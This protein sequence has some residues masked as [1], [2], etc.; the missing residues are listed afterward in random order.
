MLDFAAFQSPVG[1]LELAAFGDSLVMCDWIG[2]PAHQAS[3]EKIENLYSGQ[4]LPGGKKLLEEASVQLDEYFSGKR[5]DF[6]ISLRS[7]GS[8]FFL[9]VMEAVKGISFGK[10]MTYGELA[11]F[12]RIDSNPRTVG[13]ALKTNILSLFI[14]CHRIVALS[15]LGGYR[16]G[17]YAKSCLLQMEGRGGSL[18]FS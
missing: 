7:H 10:M 2:S 1:K 17:L 18:L 4:A 5:R 15:G 16:G 14:P 9:K 11:A 12:P 6:N 8:P 13:M 3:K